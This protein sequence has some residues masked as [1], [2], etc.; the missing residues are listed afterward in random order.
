[1]DGLLADGW[2]WMRGVLF[3]QIDDAFATHKVGENIISFSPFSVVSPE[4]H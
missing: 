4:C 3:L 2:L 1:M